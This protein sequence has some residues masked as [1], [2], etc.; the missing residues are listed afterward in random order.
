MIKFQFY[1]GT[2]AAGSLFAVAQ[3]AGA[4]G[5]GIAAVEP[6]TAAAVVATTAAITAAAAKKFK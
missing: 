6:V 2:V 4:T 3:S 5:A 1:G